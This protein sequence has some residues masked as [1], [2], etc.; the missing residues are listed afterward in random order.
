MR[1]LLDRARVEPFAFHA[2]YDRS[3]DPGACVFGPL[4]TDKY[5]GPGGRNGCDTRQ[6]VLLDQ[7]SDIEMRWGSKCRIYEAWL[8]DPYSGERLTW[9]DDGYYLQIDHIYPL[10]TAW[11]GGA[12]AWPRRRRVVF[13][14]DV[15]R[16]LLAVSGR[17]NQDKGARGPAEWLPPWRPGRCPYVT[18][19]LRVAEHYDLPITP[20]DATAIRRVA[21]RSC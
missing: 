7:M 13:A 15:K 18:A 14:N 9:R 2:G 12:W 19:Y 17:A 8:V 5:R 3:C 16:E 1:F 20:A 6:D 4:W 21:T 10:A 11:H